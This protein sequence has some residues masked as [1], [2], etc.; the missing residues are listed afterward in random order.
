MYI[1]IKPTSQLTH[2]NSQHNPYA[3]YTRP[4]SNPFSHPTSNPDANR[5][6]CRFCSRA[7]SLRHNLNRHVRGVHKMGEAYTCKCGETF[8]WSKTF[9]AHTEKCRYSTGFYQPELS[10]LRLPAPYV[11]VVAD[12]PMSTP[13]VPSASQL[14]TSS[15]RMYAGTSSSDAHQLHHQPVLPEVAQ[16]LSSVEPSSNMLPDVSNSESTGSK[17]ETGSAVDMSGRARDEGTLD[18]QLRQIVD[19]LPLKL[20]PRLPEHK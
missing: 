8:H 7:F 15:N 20:E 6:P 10:G 12:R 9:K 11:D 2:Q 19:N 5:F 13:R 1:D 17:V 4:A 3:A 18:E 16:V 14:M